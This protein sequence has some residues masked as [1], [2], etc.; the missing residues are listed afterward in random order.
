MSELA[1]SKSTRTNV[2]WAVSIAPVEDVGDPVE[3]TPPVGPDAGPSAEAPVEPEPQAVQSVP[4]PAVPAAAS[5]SSTT[6]AQPA[7]VSAPAEPSA[8]AAQVQQVSGDAS[9]APH[10]PA[11]DGQIQCD[12]AVVRALMD[13]LIMPDG[14]IQPQERAFA[15][16]LLQMVIGHASARS[17]KL[18]CERLANM[19]D[20]PAALISRFL[21]DSEIEIAEPLLLR[22][23]CV[24]ESELI[25]VVETGDHQRG[26]LI[27]RRRHLSPVVSTALAKTNNDDIE[28]DLVRNTHA[29]LSQEAV[30]RLTCRAEQNPT[31]IEALVHR[32]EMTSAC[33]LYL[34]WSMSIQQRTYTLGRFLVDV[35]VLKHVLEMS[36]P[37][38]ELVAAAVRGPASPSSG[39]N[40]DR[41]DNPA[42]REISDMIAASA[43]AGF[44]G[45]VKLLSEHTDITEEASARIVGDK[46]GEPLVVACK[47]LGVARFAFSNVV[48]RLQIVDGWHGDV[49]ALKILY[50]RLSFRQAR[51]ALT[52]W[53][54]Q[55]RRVGP[56]TDF[57]CGD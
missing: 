36:E 51:M 55:A 2:P 19:T 30:E 47:A 48:D 13:H 29:Q 41:A 17:K 56:Y 5:P 3:D 32:P 28:L 12:E 21:N 20:A 53:D 1:K 6:S 33:A 4:S 23:A 43:S 44:H 16:D 49:E 54:W 11:E 46:G 8:P 38:A 52:Y 42:K 25:S 22:A 24:S 31:L 39:A 10:T 14:Q 35:Q 18:L 26:R 34:F 15:A 37:G 50:D 7:P 57:P 9:V 40:S 27:A 45:L